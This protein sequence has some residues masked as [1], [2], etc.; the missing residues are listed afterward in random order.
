[1][2]GISDFRILLDEV[3]NERE[4]ASKV[5]K[6]AYDDAGQDLI[7]LGV[8]VDM[9]YNYLKQLMDERGCKHA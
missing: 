9:A 1:M 6:S 4:K 2:Y 5:S 8:I 7:E 3:E